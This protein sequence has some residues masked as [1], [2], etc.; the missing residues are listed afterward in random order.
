MACGTTTSSAPMLVDLVDGKPIKAVACPASRADACS[1]A[2]QADLA[3]ARDGG[4][5]VGCAREKTAKQPIPQQ[6]AAYARTFVKIPDDDRLHAGVAGG[7]SHHPEALPHR[8]IL[9]TCRT[10]LG[11]TTG[12]S[13]SVSIA[14]GGIRAAGPGPARRG[15]TSEA[16]VATCRR[17][18]CGVSVGSL[19]EKARRDIG[20]QYPP[21]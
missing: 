14:Q 3:D 18:N 16:K 4:P 13:G 7:R 20:R 12:C 19:V 10:R 11:G 21:E 15:L 6:A 5:A 1:I 8:S 2:S 9:R 17:G